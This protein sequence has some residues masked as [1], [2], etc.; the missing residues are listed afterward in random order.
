MAFANLGQVF[1][2]SFVKAGIPKTRTFGTL[3]RYGMNYGRVKIYADYDRY[4]K[5]YKS[6]EAVSKLAPREKV[7]KKLYTEMER[8]VRKNYRWET[9]ITLENKKTGQIFTKSM[10]VGDYQ[11]RS[12]NYIQQKAISQTQDYYTRANYDVIGIELQAAW[13]KEGALWY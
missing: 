6:L 9:E 2:R 10:S 12:V 5:M 11:N 8:Q 13:H 1:V 7:P 4:K 3:L